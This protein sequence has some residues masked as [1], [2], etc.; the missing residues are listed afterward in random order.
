MSTELTDRQE[1]FIREYLIDLNASAA[2]RRAGYAAKSSGPQSAALM[3]HPLISARIRA[4]LDEIYAKLGLHAINVWRAQ[5]RIA[6]FD[7]SKLLDE[8]GWP[9]PLRELDKDTRAAMSV[10]YD[11]RPDGSFVVR[12]RPPARQS[13]LSAIARRF[14]LA[15]SEPAPAQDAALPGEPEQPVEPE[16]ALEPLPEQ[17]AAALPE[18]SRDPAPVETGLPDG[19]ATAAGAQAPDAR[20]PGPLAATPRTVPPRAAPPDGARPA[21][22]DADAPPEP[23]DADLPPEP[24]AGGP[25]FLIGPG[26]RVPPLPAGPKKPGP[27]P[28]LSSHPWHHL[29]EVNDEPGR[30]G[31]NRPRREPAEPAF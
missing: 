12:V 13:A 25:G 3:K 6:F 17:P 30:R 22:A 21:H 9:K 31:A 18:Q 4:A 1:L 16:A 28:D 5:A 2:A 11:L 7:A 23:A 15:G 29:L 10:S 27:P 8:F 19:P 24:A 26:Y 14:A 20:W